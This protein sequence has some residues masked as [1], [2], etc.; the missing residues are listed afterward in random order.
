MGI[1]SG[2][3]ETSKNK[4]LDFGIPR[5]VHRLLLPVIQA[6]CCLSCTT[7]AKWPWVRINSVYKT[8][9]Y[10]RKAGNEVIELFTSE[11]AVRSQKLAHFVNYVHYFHLDT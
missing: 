9:D 2:Q 5:A 11:V 8:Y 1:G 4:V 6:N 3:N 7:L 10:N